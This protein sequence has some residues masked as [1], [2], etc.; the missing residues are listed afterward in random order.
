MLAT[1]LNFKF[2]SKVVELL[3]KLTYSSTFA[4]LEEVGVGET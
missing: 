3:N 1:I 4:D 2:N